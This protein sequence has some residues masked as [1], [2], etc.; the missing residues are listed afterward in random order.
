MR[1][2]GEINNS[3]RKKKDEIDKL[4]SQ[5]QVKVSPWPKREELFRA[6]WEKC[7]AVRNAVSREL[8]ISRVQVWRLAKRYGLPI[9]PSTRPDASGGK[10]KSDL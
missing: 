7:N 2:T 8:G 1:A 4:L 5:P 10:R 3:M 9:N 6:A